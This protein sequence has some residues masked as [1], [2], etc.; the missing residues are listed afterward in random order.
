VAADGKML[1][2]SHDRSE[3]KKALQHVAILF[4]GEEVRRRS[5]MP[6]FPIPCAGLSIHLVTLDR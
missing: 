2:R 5:A 4:E 6:I 3:D 1:R